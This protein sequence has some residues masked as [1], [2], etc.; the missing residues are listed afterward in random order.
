MR[1]AMLVNGVQLRLTPPPHIPYS[2]L[3]TS[4]TLIIYLLSYLLLHL[5]LQHLSLH[6]SIYPYTPLLPL[7]TVFIS[8]LFLY[9]PHN[10]LATPI[11]LY[12]IFS[13]I[14]YYIYYFTTLLHDGC[15]LY[16]ISSFFSLFYYISV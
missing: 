1:D 7:L 16:Y 13:F 10:I 4:I 3:Y 12:H 8:P 2:L 14:L 15:L 9:L 6:F 11:L 5:S